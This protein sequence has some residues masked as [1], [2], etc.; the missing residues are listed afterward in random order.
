MKQPTFDEVFSLANLYEALMKCRKGVGWKGTVQ[1]YT[2]HAITNLYKTKIALDKRKVNTGHFFCFVRP[3][4]GKLRYIKSVHISERVIQRCLCDNCLVPLL[5][6]K[7]IYDNSA[8]IKG[9]GVHF[10]R[11]RMKTH[12][13]R[14]WLRHGNMGY[15]LQFDFR[16]YFDTI[17]HD[18]M[19]EMVSREMQ[20]EELRAIY[21]QLV[22][23]FPGDK[24]LGL[25]SQISQISALHYPHEID[26]R[27][28][29]DKRIFAYARYM[30]DGY[31]ICEDKAYLKRC[32]EELKLMARSLG[33]E[34]NENKTQIRKLGCSFEFLKARFRLY[35][36]GRIVVRPNRKNITRNRRKLKA[37][38]AKGL[39]LPEIDMVFKT[40]FGNY[41]GF[42]AYHTRRNYANLYYEL[43]RSYGLQMR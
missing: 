7:F 19:I 14:Y 43:R 13:R 10:A 11:K 28:A 31:L 33:L 6:R 17:P 41:N 5:T 36:N 8:C 34:I 29:Y 32:L 12:L 42:N 22:N 16:H 39:P 30:D 27:F 4:R 21:A 9:K 18:K 15:I 38:F 2:N 3:E 24:G 37:L 23:D 1:N 40:T 20:D 26:N 25:G 35:G